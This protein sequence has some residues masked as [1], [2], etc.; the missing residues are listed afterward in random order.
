MEPLCPQE[1]FLILAQ[2]EV[3]FALQQVVN[4]FF[5]GIGKPGLKYQFRYGARH[6]GVLSVECSAQNIPDRVGGLG[7]QRLNH[8][9]KLPQTIP[10]EKRFE[11]ASSSN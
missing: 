7:L 11:K 6:S 10:G 8:I 3:A 9:E 1:G 4:A 5:V 2:A